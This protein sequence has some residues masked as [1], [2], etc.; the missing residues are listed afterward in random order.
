M[1]QS[2]ALKKKGSNPNKAQSPLKNMNFD[3]QYRS[4]TELANQF[5]VKREQLANERNDKA[6]KEHAPIAHKRKNS[7]DFIPQQGKSKLVEYK[8]VIQSSSREELGTSHIVVGK[9]QTKKILFQSGESIQEKG[10]KLPMH[11]FRFRTSSQKGVTA[12]VHVTGETLGNAEE[13][14]DI[15]DLLNFKQVKR[16]SV[17]PATSLDQFLEEQQ[18]QKEHDINDLPNCKQVK[19]KSV[20]P[21]TSLDQFNKK[22]A[23]HIGDETKT[24]NHTVP[25]DLVDKEEIGGDKCAIDEEIGIDCSTKGILEPKK[26][27]GKTTCKDIHAINLEE[28]KEVTFDKG[29]AVGPTGKIVSEL[30]NFIGTISRNPRFINL[31]YTSWHAVPKDT[32]KRMWEYINSKF[33]IPVEGK[34]WVMTGLRDAWKRHKQKIKERCFDKNS[35]VEDMLAKRPNDIPEGQFRQLIKYWKHPTVQAMCEMNSQNRKKQKWRHRMGPINFARVRVAL[36]ATKE[37][38]EEPSKCE[39]FIATRTKTGKEIQADTQVAIA[40]LQKHQNFGETA[41][42][43]F[44]AVFGKEQPGRLRC[45]GRSVTTSSLKKDEETNE[46]KQK[47]AN[48]ITSLKEEMTEM[49]EEMRHF[50]S[51]LLQNNPG[52]NVRDMPGCVG[53]NIASPI[54]ASSAQAVKGQNLP[55]S[56]GSTHDPILQK[57]FHIFFKYS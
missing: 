28:R 51:Q 38:N 37:N 22:Q 52:L 16:K 45:Y 4:S 24:D 8:S 21:A 49:R 57:V 3:M 2:V 29:Q 33:L 14:H 39:M 26:V 41:D 10:I 23:I 47:H 34:K 6:K 55:H 30:T 35:T 27:R 19:R 44:T 46:L 11:N 36:R 32:K 54:D 31:M 56:S 40:E 20:I 25:D 15:Q 48:E 1:S 42:D 12:S 7:E 5:K 53:S 18:L 13:Q 43:A 9:G 50:F 17:L